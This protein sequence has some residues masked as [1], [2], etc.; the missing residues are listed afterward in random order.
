MSKLGREEVV[1]ESVAEGDVEVGVCGID[2]DKGGFWDEGGKSNGG[3]MS[4][5]AV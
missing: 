1:T 4:R 5:T 3:T 2:E